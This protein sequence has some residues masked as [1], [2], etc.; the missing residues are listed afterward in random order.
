LPICPTCQAPLEPNARFCPKDGTTV[1]PDSLPGVTRDSL[2][3]QP[4]ARAAHTLP[5]KRKSTATTSSAED[6]LIG[7]LLNGRYRVVAR[8]GQG[9]V[10]AVYE[11]EHVE[12]GKPVALKVLHAM[13]GTIDEFVK[14]FE[15]EARA[16]SKLS[17]PGCVQV[18]DF[19]RV[20]SVSAGCW[21]TGSRS[22][23]LLA[24]D[25]PRPRR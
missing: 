20:V 15:R 1:G 9:G 3:A 6:P 5:S 23:R 7:R 18:M 8:L 10:G 4:G 22:R 25:F 14:R 2:A 17:H 19:G 21:S 13:F 16:A 11:A 12:I 24:V